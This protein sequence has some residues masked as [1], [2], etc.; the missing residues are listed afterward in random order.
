[1]E[2]KGGYAYQLNIRLVWVT[3]L[4]CVVHRLTDFKI[5]LIRDRSAYE[6]QSSVNA[7][8]RRD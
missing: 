1:M 5:E 3:A 6:Y 7:Q 8:F 4:K 2:S